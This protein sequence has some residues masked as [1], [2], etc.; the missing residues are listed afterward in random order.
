MSGMFRRP[1]DRMS[2]KNIQNIKRQLLEI[3]VFRIDILRLTPFVDELLPAKHSKAPLLTISDCL[4][5]PPDCL[6]QLADH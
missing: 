1:K 5:C 2:Y 4:P 3:E 6:T